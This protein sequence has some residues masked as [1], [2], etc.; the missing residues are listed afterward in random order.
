MGPIGF[1]MNDDEYMSLAAQMLGHHDLDGFMLS[2]EMPDRTDC[3]FHIMEGLIASEDPL[4]GCHRLALI[5][6]GVWRDDA[7]KLA[8]EFMADE[9]WVRA[10]RPLP[11]AAISSSE[12]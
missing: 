6:A 5:A 9:L 4:F 3:L 12:E 2:L 1:E 10:A 7:G 8:A 11:Q